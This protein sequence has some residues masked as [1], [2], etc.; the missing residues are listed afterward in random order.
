[1]HIM[2]LFRQTPGRIYF[3]ETND[4]EILAR[5]T[6]DV[7]LYMSDTPGFT[8][9]ATIVFIAT[10]HREGSFGVSGVRIVV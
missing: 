3:R 6:V 5:A 4:T 7:L 8:F 10:W 9:N 1:M 2:F